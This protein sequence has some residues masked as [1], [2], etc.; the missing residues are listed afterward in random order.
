MIEEKLSIILNEE[1]DVYVCP[2][3]GDPVY[4]RETRLGRQYYVCAT[5][6]CGKH[7]PLFRIELKEICQ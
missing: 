6:T 7:N 4:R 5:K 3:C 1:Y 2:R